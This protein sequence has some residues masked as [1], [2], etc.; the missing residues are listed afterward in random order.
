MRT[1]RR[2]LAVAL[3][4][5][6]ALAGP[7]AAQPAT[8]NST[9]FSVE[10]FAPAPGPNGF[11]AVED[12]DVMTSGEY[13]VGLAAS[14]MSRPIVFRD[15]NSGDEELVPVDLRFGF[16][17]GAAIGLGARY[18]LGIAYPF[19]VQSGDRLQGIGLSDEEL[20][21]FAGGDPRLHAKLRLAGKPGE[22]GRA[23]GMSIALTLPWGDSDHFAGERGV[24]VAWHLIGSWRSRRF[25]VAANLGP[26]IRSSEVVLLSPARPHGNEI[27]ASVAA[28]AVIPFLP[29]D[30]LTALAEYSYVRG[31][32]T[33]DGVRGQSPGEARL[34]ARLRLPSALSFTAAFGFGT[35]PD[36]VGSPAW[37]IIGA[38]RWDTNPVSD[39]DRDG[40]PDGIDQCS[41][42]PEDRDDYA[43][44]DGCPDP[45]N[46]ADGVPDDQDKCPLDPE[47]R[48]GDY[49]IDGCPE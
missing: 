1:E 31:D 20:D 19:A 28:E 18:Q 36:D 10:R 30:Y 33:A 39:L 8:D 23:I 48:D 38:V 45:D 17:L 15:I 2:A 4:L 13:S 12:G 29:H 25:G 41:C 22:L 32:S 27:T 5:V 49:D 42:D 46:D 44:S 24:V 26:R 43:D 9:S 14:L 35:T 7:A 40:I 21:G 6:G 11:L 47:D 3:V 34:G 16:E 37:R